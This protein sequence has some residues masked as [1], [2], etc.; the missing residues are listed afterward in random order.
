MIFAVESLLLVTVT[1]TALGGVA[2]SV[3]D[4]VVCR[5]RPTVTLAIVMLGAV[6]VA[7][8]CCPVLGVLNPVGVDT[9]MVD[10][11]LAAGLGAAE[12]DTLAELLGTIVR[13]NE[14]PVVFRE[15]DEGA[16]AAGV[17]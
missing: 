14:V 2:P 6:T 4:T 9:L 7:V 11:P 15:P 13:D 3:T 1:S 16:P 5:S 12:R 10:V 8:I 17:R